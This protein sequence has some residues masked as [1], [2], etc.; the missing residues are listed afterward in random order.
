MFGNGSRK[1]LDL[2]KVFFRAGKLDVQSEFFFTD[3]NSIGT[4]NKV[5]PNICKLIEETCTNF[6]ECILDSSVLENAVFVNSFVN[7]RNI[8]ITDTSFKSIADSSHKAVK[9]KTFKIFLKFPDTVHIN[10]KIKSFLFCIS[11]NSKQGIKTG[12][13]HPGICSSCETGKNGNIFFGFFGRIIKNMDVD[14]DGF[15]DG[16]I[17]HIA[18]VGHINSNIKLY[19]IIVAVFEFTNLRFKKLI[20]QNVGKCFNKGIE[21][22]FIRIGFK[23]S[24]F[25][26]KFNCFAVHGGDGCG[27]NFGKNLVDKTIKRIENCTK[28]VD[29]TCLAAEDTFNIHCGN[30]AESGTD[31]NIIKVSVERSNIICK[32]IGGNYINNKIPVNDS[33]SNVICNSSC[34]TLY[35]CNVFFGA[36][37]S[38]NKVKG[39]IINGYGI[40]AVN[41]IFAEICKFKEETCTDFKQSVFDCG[42]LENTV[43]VNGIINNSNNGISDILFNCITDSRHKT[44]KRSTGKV[45]FEFPDTVHIDNDFSLCIG[46]I[47]IAFH[48]GIKACTCS[49]GIGIINNSSKQCLA[50]FNRFFNGSAAICTNLALKAVFKPCGSNI[51]VYTFVGMGY[52]FFKTDGNTQDISCITGQQLA[53]FII[54]SPNELI[55]YRLFKKNRKAKSQ[56]CICGTDD[57]VIVN[58]TQ[59]IFC[60]NKLFFSICFCRKGR[61]NKHHDHH[62]GK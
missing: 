14:I 60:N 44:V 33:S 3:S 43:F 29:C 16:G 46:K 30:K 12:F 59:A 32:C 17:D 25:I 20:A 9:R 28:S 58:V 21:R 56:S 51:T 39:F 55:A 23:R 49:P 42:V 19:C 8:G 22:S 31:C 15:C 4:K 18:D 45:F 37:K 53:V 11:F 48:K 52:L 27:R 7:N 54:I 41:K 50:F 24:I 35:L 38:D 62:C 5:F 57:T 40:C 34:K 36:V 1:A 2:C 61:H 10:N 47:N 26:K 6:K 13:R